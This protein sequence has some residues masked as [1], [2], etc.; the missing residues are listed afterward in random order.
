MGDAQIFLDEQEQRICVVEQERD[1]ARN[2][3]LDILIHLE[4]PEYA[5]MVVSTAMQAAA[6]ER[7]AAPTCLEE[8]NLVDKE[9]D[10]DASGLEAQ[11]LVGRRSRSPTQ[12]QPPP[13]IVEEDA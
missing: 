4:G 1:E 2:R 5:E 8:L 12:W 10:G 7:I 3:L 6:N 11:W 9:P 13:T